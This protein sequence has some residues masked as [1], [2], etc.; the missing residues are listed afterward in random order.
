M[1]CAYT[2]IAFIIR[3]TQNF[4]SWLRSHHKVRNKNHA[5]CPFGFNGFSKPLCLDARRGGTITFRHTAFCQVWCHARKQFLVS[6]WAPSPNC[7][8]RLLSSTFLSVC[9]SAWNNSAST[10]RIFMKFEITFFFSRKSVE[11]IQASLKPGKNNGYLTLRPMY[12]YDSISLS[13]S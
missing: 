12:I 11:K 1:Y 4:W 10:G 2:I 6:F 9:P 5:T 13:S 7:E 3:N 8:K